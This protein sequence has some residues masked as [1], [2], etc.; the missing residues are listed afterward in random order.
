MKELLSFLLFC[1]ISNFIYAQPGHTYKNLNDGIG[2]YIIIDSTTNLNKI[3]NL[4]EA[5]SLRLI[6]NLEEIP[7]QFNDFKNIESMT[8]QS[9]DKLKD[10]SGLNY[11]TNLEELVIYKYYGTFLSAKKLRLNSLKSL[12]ITDA[13]HLENIDALTDLPLLE[14]LDITYTPNI[15]RFPKFK[16]HNQIKSLRIDHVVEKRNQVYNDNYLRN[17]K[18]L[19]KLES[20]TLANINGLDKI[21]DFLPPNLSYLEL[22][23]WA[24][25]HWDNEKIEVNDLSNI[26][27]FPNLKNLKL[28]YVHINCQ[29]QKFPN[30]DLENLYLNYA[31]TKNDI[32]WVFSFKSIENLWMNYCFDLKTIEPNEYS[33]M[34]KSIEIENTPLQSIDFFLELKNT[35]KLLIHHAPDLKIVDLNSLD[36][37]PNISIFVPKMYNLY[38]NDDI[39][40][41]KEYYNNVDN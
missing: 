7:T 2:D 9:D 38:K 28:Y 23:G 31:W 36:N 3:K 35:N 15:K 13:V 24:Q 27:L 34:I 11:F 32:S 30:T 19:S 8:I 25:K 41:L 21:P 14:K 1:T 4:K 10:L 40:K 5:K 37:I 18:Y 29:Y 6:I 33:D 17:I 39:W 22:S 12:R 16:T 20:L 26:S